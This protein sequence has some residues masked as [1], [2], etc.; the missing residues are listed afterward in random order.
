MKSANMTENDLR[1]YLDQIF[2][3]VSKTTTTKGID[4]MSKEILK[5]DNDKSQL[6]MQLGK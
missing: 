6:I 1:T 2:K 5:I 3:L 4:V